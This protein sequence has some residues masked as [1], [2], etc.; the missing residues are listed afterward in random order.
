MEAKKQ[1]KKFIAILL[2]LTMVFALA[3][4]GEKTPEKKPNETPGTTV[5]DPTQETIDV[6]AKKAFYDTYFT[7]DAF[8]PA[9]TSYK[10]SS[11]GV[12]MSQVIDANGYGILEIMVGDYFVRVYRTEAGVYLHSHGP[13]EE[14][15]EAAEDAWLKYT[16]KEG[17]NILQS[18]EMGGNSQLELPEKYTV[19]YVDT[20]EGVDIVQLETANEDYVEGATYNEY[21]IKFTYED[22]E[23]TVTYFQMI[24]DGAVMSM[25]SNTEDLPESLSL[26]DYDFDAEAKVLVNEDDENDKI[27]CEILETR[28]ATPEKTSVM[29]LH[30][31][32][33][34]HKVLKVTGKDNG[35]D[36]TLE[37]MDVEKYETDVTFPEEV[38]EC[39]EEELGLIILAMLMMTMV[40]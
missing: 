11:E 8:Q 13:S 7:S 5:T 30:I 2:A 32:A 26:S 3:A 4:C 15:P 25:W 20:K 9:G 37:F 40:P 18:E 24:N 29:E 17:E 14:N 39:T 38:A 31:D 33:E 6:A 35:V 21:D 1:M 28:D 22:K 34:S 19:T 27:T 36:T 10:A 16:E 12:S 23:Y